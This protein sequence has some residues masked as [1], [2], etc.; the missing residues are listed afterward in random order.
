METIVTQ[1]PD[2]FEYRSWVAQ[3]TSVGEVADGVERQVDEA[4]REAAVLGQVVRLV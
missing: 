3:L 4:T 2:G 1:R